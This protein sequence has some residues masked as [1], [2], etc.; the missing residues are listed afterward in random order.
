MTDIEIREAQTFFFHI[1]DMLVGI[2]KAQLIGNVDFRTIP[3]QW[4]GLKSGIT[5]TSKTG[6]GFTLY[7]DYLAKGNQGKEIVV[8]NRDY[9]SSRPGSTVYEHIRYEDYLQGLDFIVNYFH[10][11][12][13]LGNVAQILKIQK[14][15]EHAM[16]KPTPKTLITLPQNGK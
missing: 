5:E 15:Q 3:H 7:L 12:F 11:K 13:D 8:I 10:K 16:L 2:S 9:N 1:N 4:P 14:Q 6:Y